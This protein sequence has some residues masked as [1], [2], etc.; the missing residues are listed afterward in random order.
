MSVKENYKKF[1][2]G[3]E[4]GDVTMNIVSTYF[5]SA[6]PQDP[7]EFH[8]LMMHWFFSSHTKGCC[9]APRGHAKSTMCSMVGILIRIALRMDHNLMIFSATLPL[10]ID[11]LTAIKTELQSNEQFCQDFDIDVSKARTWNQDEIELILGGTFPMRLSVKSCGMPMRGTKYANWRPSF[12]LL[13]DIEDEE[14]V[15]NPESRMK[16]HKWMYSTL[17]PAMD[18]TKQKIRFVGTVMHEDSLLNNCLKNYSWVTL[19][20]EAHNDSFDQV[21][22]PNRFT[23]KILMEIYKEYCDVGTPE[24]YSQEYRNKCIPEGGAF[25]IIS[26]IG[27]VNEEP[28]DVTYWTACDLAISQKQR[29]DYTVIATVASDDE[30]LYIVDIK[31]G[32][33]DA[34]EI[35]DNMLATERQ[36]HPVTFVIEKGQIAQAI[37]PLLELEERKYATYLNKD[38]V[39]S[40]KDKKTRARTLQGLVRLGLCK[41]VI[42]IDNIGAM[43]NEM[44][45]FGSAKHD[46]IV[47]ALSYIAMKIN[48]KVRP[49]NKEEAAAAIQTKV[50]AEAARTSGVVDDDWGFE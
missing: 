41:V 10:A 19:F 13:D 23:R 38:F 33:W 5:H 48:D 30:Y 6:C 44:E 1:S 18:V 40:Q 16:L 26:N 24:I 4:L 49:I 28:D 27:R 20:F 36:Y 7:P 9:A 34:Q 43:L 29:A 46:D 22:W 37:T 21:L 50:F 42:G 31:R 14:S 32:R 11:L 8:R 35:V 39:P 45:K 17:L 2:S 15:A 25:F 47:D 3:Q 12:V